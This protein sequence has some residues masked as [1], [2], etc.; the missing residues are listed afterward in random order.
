MWFSG[1]GKRVEEGGERIEIKESQ[2][3][4]MGNSIQ[5]PCHGGLKVNYILFICLL[6]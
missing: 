6:K 4:T 5:I 1:G 2:I 3:K